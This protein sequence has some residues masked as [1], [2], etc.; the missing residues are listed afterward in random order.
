M[1][2]NKL[3]MKLKQE[4]RPTEKHLTHTDQVT[5]EKKDHIPRA[6]QNEKHNF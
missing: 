3:T 5:Q 2:Q 4:R 1:V 6:I